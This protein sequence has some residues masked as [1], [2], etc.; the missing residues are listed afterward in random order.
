MNHIKEPLYRKINKRVR[1]CGA[2][3]DFG[4]DHRHERHTKA[5]KASIAEGVTRSS[6]HA[7]EQRGLDYT[8]LYR[9]LLSK[10]GQDW[11]AVH[12]EAVSRLDKPDPIFHLVAQT[13]DARHD[14]V[15]G[16]ETS[17]FSGLYVDP[18]FAYSWPNRLHPD[19]AIA[20]SGPGA[21]A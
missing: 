18:V 9:F 1:K 8:P 12:S 2:Y 5:T 6:M 21:D 3:L 7:K 4:G 10:V 13:E 20:L 17:Y 14:F 15:N 11:D 19:E 16:G